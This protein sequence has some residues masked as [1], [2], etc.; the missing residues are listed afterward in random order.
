MME[1]LIEIEITEAS[2]GK[3]FTGLSPA[4]PFNPPK[5]KE[6]CRHCGGTGQVTMLRFSVPCECVEPYFGWVWP[7][8]NRTVLYYNLKGE[9]VAVACVSTGSEPPNPRA[10]CVGRLCHYSRR[11]HG[12]EL[13][14]GRTKSI[15]KTIR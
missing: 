9:E 13:R 1:K 5:P 4:V 7:G 14:K 10:T 12:Y 2:A 6:D 8:A 3:E 11:A 15:E